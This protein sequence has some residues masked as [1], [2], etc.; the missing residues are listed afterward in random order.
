MNLLPKEQEMFGSKMPKITEA[1]W[2]AIITFVVAQ[3]VAWGVVDNEHAKVLISA[4]G[5]LIPVFHMLADAFL[6]SAR[7][8]AVSA[9]P[10]AFKES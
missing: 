2:L 4:G 1:Q 9:N 8:K 3:L 7:V 10:D 6:R 5:T